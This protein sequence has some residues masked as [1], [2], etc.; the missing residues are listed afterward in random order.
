VGDDAARGFSSATDDAA[1]A[2]L[3]HGEGSSA[4]AASEAGD[5]VVAGEVIR[6]GADAAIH[7]GAA[8]SH[9]DDR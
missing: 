2:A 6:V 8:L 5:S 3:Y 4:S 7:A 1:G 9:D